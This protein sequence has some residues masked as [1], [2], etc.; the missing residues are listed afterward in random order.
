MCTHIYTVTILSTYCMF[1]FIVLVQ[2]YVFFL[3]RKVRA[4][5]NRS[6]NLC[7][8]TYTW[9]IKPILIID[10][11]DAGA[12]VSIDA[13]IGRFKFTTDAPTVFRCHPRAI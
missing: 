9:Q 13:N 11:D 2:M 7:M 3:I 12:A 1:C 10:Y 8:R 6:Q 5:Q 4:M